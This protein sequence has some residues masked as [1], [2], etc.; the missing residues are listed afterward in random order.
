MLRFATACSLIV[1]VS[2]GFSACGSASLRDDPSGSGGSAG[3]GGSLSLDS[4]VGGGGDA[5]AP[6]A[7]NEESPCASG[8]V[9]VGAAGDGYCKP[10]G[11]ACL[12]NS[13]CA[14]DSYCCA[15][16]CRAD[17]ETDGVCTPFDN[18]APVD[19]NC[20]RD[21]ASPGVFSPALQCAWTGPLENDPFPEHSRVLA[22][23][24]VGDLPIDSGASAEIVIVTS[25]A[26]QGA[27]ADES[28]ELLGGVIRVLNGQTCEQVAVIEDSFGVRDNATPALGDLDGDGNLEIV[29]RTTLGSGYDTLPTSVVAFRWSG[30]ELGFTRVWTSDVGEVTQSGD[31]WD[32][33]SLH[34]LN[35]DGLAEIIG[36]N[37]EVIDRNG[38]RLNPGQ[39]GVIVVSEPVLGDLDNDGQVELLANKVF[40]YNSDVN[41]WEVAYPGVNATNYESTPRFYGYADFGTPGASPGDFNNRQLDGRAEI[42]VSGPLGNSGGEVAV[43]TLEG[44]EIM[45]LTGFDRGGP[46]TIGDFDNDG[47]PEFASAGAD[48]YRVFDLDCKGGGPGCE[49]D[50]VLWSQPSQDTSSAQTG[51]SIFDFEGDG[52]AEAVYADEC[53]LRIYEGDTGSVLFSA[54]RQ[55]CTWWELPIVADPDNDTRTEIIVNSNTNCSVACDKLDPL[56]EGVRCKTGADCISGRCDAG[57]CRCTDDLECGN[58]FD[59]P[60]WEVGI[61]AKPGLVC[62]A[63]LEGTPGNGNVC[64]SQHPMESYKPEGDKLLSGVK[65]YRDKLDRWASSRNLWNQHAYSITN[66]NDDG[67][68]P[69]TSEWQQNFLQEGLNNFRQNR[70]GSVGAEAL[71]DITGK[72]ESD[73]VCVQSGSAISLN[74]T[75][76]NRGLR[77]VGADMPA[78]FYVGE[79]APENIVCVTKT[80]GPVP[81]G[82]CLL[83]RCDIE[84]ALPENSQVTMVVNDNGTGRGATTEECNLDN[85]TSQVRIERCAVIR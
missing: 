63:P 79:L 67:S 53:F 11:E 30:S 23:P 71:P 61:G 80:D 17:G 37:G 69:R 5:A 46:P 51:S 58:T 52:K 15:A 48:A 78:T 36:R 19:P 34:D 73:Q 31:N 41:Q 6:V 56:H 45:K 81:V 29:T 28:P 10:A 55:S 27:S 38:Q 8:Q 57:F 76:C 22:S 47:F 82:G 32:G 44:Q 7:C 60:L 3:S 72:L 68:V 84:Q 75:V 18:D 83:V 24:V 13:D 40:R 49:G 20:K 85:N 1:I 74:A 2:G 25:R 26:I 59:A 77:A 12:S 54:Y 50:Y 4:G 14:S 16:D 65:V 9:C 66:I 70:Q 64:R 43:Y 39:A 33:V 21:A 35:D 62:V 42:V